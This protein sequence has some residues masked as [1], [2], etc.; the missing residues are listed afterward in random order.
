MPEYILGLPVEVQVTPS[1]L[2]KTDLG[3][4]FRVETLQSDRPADVNRQA[5]TEN[6]LKH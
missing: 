3:P 6:L 4:S 2:S 1:L 5:D